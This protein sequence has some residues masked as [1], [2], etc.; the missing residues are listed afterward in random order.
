MGKTSN[1]ESGEP[2]SHCLPVNVCEAALGGS[3][4]L[5]F[6]N[7]VMKQSHDC[8]LRALSALCFSDNSQINKVQEVSNKP[9]GKP[10]CS[11]FHLEVLNYKASILKAFSKPCT[12]HYEL[13]TGQLETESPSGQ[14]KKK[15]ARE[16]ENQIILN[17]KGI[18]S[19]LYR[20]GNQASLT[21]KSFFPRM[22]SWRKM[23]EVQMERALD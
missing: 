12:G 15:T 8:L 6:F 23:Q 5:C 21:Q 13:H 10:F 19:L 18:S 22:N 16:S 1:G 17:P 14:S 20:E 9:R 11:Q 4:G 3:L 7:C 2:S